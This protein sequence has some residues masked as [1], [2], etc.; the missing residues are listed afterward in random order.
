[1]R[2]GNYEGGGIGWLYPNST[3]TLEKTIRTK[4]QERLTFKS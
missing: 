2:K 1:M 4:H 3:D